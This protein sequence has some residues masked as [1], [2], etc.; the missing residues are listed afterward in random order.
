MILDIQLLLPIFLPYKN[1]S[2]S[3]MAQQLN[4]TVD[5]LEDELVLLIRNGKIKARIDSKNKILYVAD[6]DQRWY[7]YQHALTVTKQ[8]EKTTKSLLLRS[9]ILKANLM[10]RDESSTTP[11]YQQINSNNDSE[12]S[13]LFYRKNPRHI[14]D[15][16]MSDDGAS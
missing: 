16:D 14:Q 8:C 10:V 12:Y 3:T 1:A 11:H 7:A 2:M 6:T 13:T 15:G 9:A 4:T 5:C